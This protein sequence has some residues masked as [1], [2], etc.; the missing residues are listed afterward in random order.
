MN[1]YNLASY[2]LNVHIFIAIL[3]T[4]FG[5]SRSNN[6]QNH[7]PAIIEVEINE[8]S[9]LIFDNH[10]VNLSDFTMLVENRINKLVDNGVLREQILFS[11][12]VA[13]NVKM[14]MVSDVQ[15]QLRLLDVK[16]IIYLK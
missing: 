9:E 5:C 12:S 1:F 11:F 13:K 10:V 4:T 15:K 2:N 6:N 14:G 16:K 7:L 8:A 3:I